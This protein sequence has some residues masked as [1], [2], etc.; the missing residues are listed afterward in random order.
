M[1][2][3]CRAA[4][5]SLRGT[6]W[7]KSRH[8][9]FVVFFIVHLSMVHFLH[10]MRTQSVARLLLCYH[11][12]RWICSCVLYRR[13]VDIS[14]IS[15]SWGKQIGAISPLFHS[16]C[17]LLTPFISLPREYWMIYRG[18]GFLAVVW[19]GSSPPLPTSPVSNLFLFLSIAGRAFWRER[20]DGREAKSYD[21]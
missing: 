6:L 8:I 1:A 3:L 5:N 21:R 7:K 2:I 10:T 16:H 12:I 17:S 14:Y 18:P 20:G 11:W 9:G 15:M 13:M 19:F 4:K